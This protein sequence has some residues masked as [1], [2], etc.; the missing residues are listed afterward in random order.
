MSIGAFKEEGEGGE[1]QDAWTVIFPLKSHLAKATARPLNLPISP[2]SPE[3]TVGQHHIT[4][5]GK[6]EEEGTIFQAR[7]ARFLFDTCKASRIAPRNI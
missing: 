5:P 4:W 7:G 1:G 3:Y 2:L 6:E